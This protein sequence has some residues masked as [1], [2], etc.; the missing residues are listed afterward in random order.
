MCGR[1]NLVTD[2]HALADAFDIILDLA[3]LDFSL[4]RFN[5]A[6]S[7][8][9]RLT[10]IPIIRALGNENTISSA[11]WPLIPSWAKGKLPKYSTANARAE[12]VQDAPSYRHAWK[13]NQRCLIPATGFYEWQ[14]I[15]GRKTKQP[16]HIFLPNTYI[17]AFAGLWESSFD[18]NDNKIIYRTD[19]RLVVRSTKDSL[20]TI[21]IEKSAKGSDYQKAK[22]RAQNIN[23][24]YILID[25]KLELDAYLTTDFENKFGEQEVTITLYLPEG[26]VLYAD[27][28]TYSFHRNSSYYQDILDNGMEEHYLK[29]I[30][31]DVICPD[32]DDNF[33][34]KIDINNERS[35]LIIDEE[36]VE[37]KSEDGSLI[38]DK[39]GVKG[40]SEDVKVNIDSSGIEITSDQN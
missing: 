40:K 1:Y 16:Y 36:G 32:C 18:E 22:S 19:V 7:S 10:K 3:Q 14:S 2:A 9:K 29:I 12:R 6:P 26:S 38:I 23:Y 33:R 8:G 31:D 34:V 28:N 13:N 35:G 11:V 21:N 24:N 15:K 27:E 25:K 39:K 5:I 4:P 17:F 37:F 30:K 20:A